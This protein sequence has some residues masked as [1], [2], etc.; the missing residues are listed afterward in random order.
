MDKEF[1]TV[2]IKQCSAFFLGLSE[3]CN[4]YL[5]DLDGQ[6]AGTGKGSKSL[7]TG[8]GQYPGGK[9]KG[10]KTKKNKADIDPDQP[11]KPSTPFFQ[12][13][14]HRRDAIKAQYPKFSATEITQL[15]SKEW[16]ELPKERIQFYQDSYKQMYA[17]YKVR[18]QAYLDKKAGKV[19]VPV[20][21]VVKPSVKK[22]ENLEDAVLGK[23]NFLEESDDGE[24][25]GDD[26]ASSGG[27]GNSG[28]DDDDDEDDA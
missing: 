14:A 9:G 27:S 12:F 6:T 26:S 24:E 2:V 13:C 28:A 20:V 11:R 23:R 17:D 7:K 15:I 1:M 25:E 4:D 19:P 10:K 5:Q 22:D 8:N 18:F 21:E 3:Y 16:K